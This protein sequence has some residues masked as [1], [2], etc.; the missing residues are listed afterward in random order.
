MKYINVERSSRGNLEISVDVLNKLIENA[1]S[2]FFKD[3][4]KSLDVENE[5]FVD[6]NLYLTLK[7]VLNSAVQITEINEKK[8]FK[9]IETTIYRTLNFKEKNIS[10]VYYQN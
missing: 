2:S 6:N 10:I 9:E 7:V 1:V 8:I 3:K 4:A 5:I